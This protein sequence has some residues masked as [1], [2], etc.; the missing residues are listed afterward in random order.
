MFKKA[1]VLLF[2]GYAS[3]AQAGFDVVAL[4]VNGG[5]IDGNLTSYLIRHDEDPRY[6]A[7]DAGSVLP[8]IA[9]ALEKGAFPGVTEQN[10]APFSPQGYV[11]RSLIAGYFISHA[12]LDHVAGLMIASTEDGKTPIYGSQ[13]TIDTLRTHYFN[14]KT[15]PNFSDSGSGSRLGTYRLQPKRAA[16]NF[17]IS[18]TKMSAR[19]Y[20]LSHSNSSS[21]ML[22][23]SQGKESFA[24][25]G[26]TGPDE[27]EKSKYLDAI[28]QV[29]GGLIQQKQLK[30]MII[31][32][33]YPNDMEDKQ[34]FGH[35]TPAWLLKELRS[36]E[37]YSGG[38]GSL[39]G[40]PVIISHI[41]PSLEQGKDVRALVAEQL[42][43]GN[44]LGV[45][46][47]LMEQ[48]DHRSF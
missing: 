5:V 16:Q 13:D 19:M 33:S 37:K 7:L 11:F 8:G 41:K 3:C 34:L 35:L 4:G 45:E 27:I 38:E 46:F 26:D 30:G 48:G 31:E 42:Q 9:K 18:D 22:L 17:T 39:R 20:P 44:S 1:A 24:Y 2:C 10:A 15:W 25:F 12:H 32:A 21:S 23:L 36:L 6:L 29:L 47:I 28:W 14:W 43:E 40:L